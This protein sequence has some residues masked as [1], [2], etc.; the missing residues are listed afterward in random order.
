MVEKQKDLIL[1]VEKLLTYMNYD[2]HS[3]KNYLEYIKDFKVSAAPDAGT[4]K[5]QLEM[6]K[7]NYYQTYLDKTFEKAFEFENEEERKNYF[8]YC[9]FYGSLGAL[10]EFQNTKNDSEP[11]LKSRLR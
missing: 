3:D 7:R 1:R 5:D 8:A 6:V 10:G 11:M 2:W 9:Q 4:E